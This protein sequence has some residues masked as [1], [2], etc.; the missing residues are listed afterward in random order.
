M[1]P[2]QHRNSTV[3]TDDSVGGLVVQ[4]GHFDTYYTTIRET[5]DF[6]QIIELFALQLAMKRT[7]ES[8]GYKVQP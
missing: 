3:S 8:P 1:F 7:E 4:P 5:N 6:Q 2:N